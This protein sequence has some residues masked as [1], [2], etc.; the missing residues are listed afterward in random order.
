MLGS[1]YFT[2]HPPMPI[3]S[4]VAQF[5]ADMIGRNDPNMLGLVGP[6]AA[7]KYQSWRLGMIVDSVNRASPSPLRIERKWDD[8]DDP[9]HVYKRSDHYNY[10]KKGI[11]IIF[12]TTGEHDD[13]HR[14][15]D[16]A[17]KIDYDK[18][19][20][21]AQLMLEAGL[22]V[23]NRSTRPTSEALTESISSRQP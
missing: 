13:Y 20:R 15:S 14:V 17:S 8:P 10:A 16:E 9:E 3:D 11:P 1:Q 22:V 2:S 21:V 18:M 12:F 7:P 5:N 6:R 19:A 23:S 4:I